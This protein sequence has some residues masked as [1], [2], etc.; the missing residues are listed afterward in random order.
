MSIFDAFSM[1]TTVTIDDIFTKKQWNWL[2]R[3][4]PKPQTCSEK[5]QNLCA[6][7]GSQAAGGT[8][9]QPV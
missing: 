9:R 1:R 8:E 5:H 4:G 6:R 2:T 3:H 7:P